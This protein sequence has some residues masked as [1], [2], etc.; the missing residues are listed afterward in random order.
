MMFSARHQMNDEARSLSILFASFILSCG[1]GHITAAWNIWNTNYWWEG[2][3]K[4]VTAGVSAYTAVSL[5]Q[6]IPIFVSIYKRLEV[7]EE[8][9]QTDALT[10]LPN[11]RALLEY[12]QGLID[13][14]GV[15]V[16]NLEL[17]LDKSKYH[18][19]ILADLDGFKLVNDNF[20]HPAGDRVLCEVAGLL[21]KNTRSEN[22]LVTRLG[23]DEFAIV[24]KGC[25]ESQALSIAQRLRK[26]TQEYA[27]SSEQAKTLGISMGFYL[28]TSEPDLETIDEIYA[29]ADQALYHAKHSGKRAIAWTRHTPKSHDIPD[30][31]LL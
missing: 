12:L 10:G 17:M 29:A 5:Y 20:G 26:V 23:G 16:P 25:D 14:G 9:L 31:Q 27:E 22:T 4:L 19:L 6:H 15:E 13:T 3:I 30:F 8:K 2:S 18:A 11:R 24:V 21:A 7:S 28:F 1:L